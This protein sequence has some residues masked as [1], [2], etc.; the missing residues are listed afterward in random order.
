MKRFFRAI[1][2][3]FAAVLVFALGATRCTT[4]DDTLGQNFIPPY[5]Q[6][7]LQ[8]A[9]LT[10]NY[11]GKAL[12]KTYLAT[13]DT[14]PSSNSGLLMVGSMIDPVL[15]RV[16]A[17]AMTDFFPQAI[18]KYTLSEEDEEEEEEEEDDKPYFGYRP[19]ADSIFIDLMITDIKGD[20]TVEQTFN[21][22]EL[23]DSL[24]RDSMY[25]FNT[26]IDESADLSEPLFTFT[27]GEDVEEN[28]LILRRLEPTPSGREFMRRIVETDNEV[29]KD[30]TY[31]FHKLFYG[32]YIAPAPGGPED[33]AVFQFY[34]RQLS[35]TDENYSALHLFAHN[36]DE[37]NPT[38]VLDTVLSVFRFSDTR[39]VFPNPNLNVNSVKFT[40]PDEIAETVNDTLKTDPGLE[41]I[42]SQGYGGLASFLRFT[43][44]MLAQLEAMKTYDGVEYSEMVINDAKIYFPMAD[45]TTENMNA[46]PTRLGMYYTYGQPYPELPSSRYP[47]FYTVPYYNVTPVYGPKPMT[48]YAYYAE[49]NPQSPTKA[50]YGGYINRTKGCYEMSITGYMTELLT[51]PKTPREIWLGPE[52][53]TRA[54]EYTR[55]SLNGSAAAENPIRI[56]ITYT[57]IK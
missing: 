23:R 11:D 7:K 31:E 5:Q 12:L 19:V 52:I 27:L 34:L 56:V 8:V 10:P 32:L 1:V 42:Y 36:Y 47:L 53:N 25:Y 4:V 6:M 21:I 24:R 43:D 15:G 50:P 44:D 41:V 13:N 14:I 17:S 39:W 54:T 45:P 20:K 35:E 28:T 9:T 48:D 38:Q 37:Q 40:Y 57:L 51:N 30:P 29:Y 26:P 22:Y 16:E 18:D 55:V 3:A 33:A 49:N 2:P 46:A